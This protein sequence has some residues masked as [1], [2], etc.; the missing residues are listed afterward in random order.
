M[1]SNIEIGERIA[2]L[3]T[4]RQWTL[5]YLA[6]QVG[7]NV[8]TIKDWE[9]GVSLPSVHNVRKLCELFSTTADYLL[10]LDHAPTIRLTGMSEN[11]INRARAIIQVLIDTAEKKTSN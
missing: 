11:E 3:R 2:A 6:R 8:K 10:D 9:N 5:T 4:E 7:T 1:R